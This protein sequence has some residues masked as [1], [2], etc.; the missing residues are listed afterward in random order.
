MN[1]KNLASKH[2]VLVDESLKKAKI[3]DLITISDERISTNLDKINNYKEM[4]NNPLMSEAYIAARRY[5]LN[6]DVAVKAIE[7]LGHDKFQEFTDFYFKII[8][9]DPKDYI[10]AVAYAAKNGFCFTPKEVSMLEQEV[11]NFQNKFNLDLTQTYHRDVPGSSSHYHEHN[12]TRA[13][14]QSSG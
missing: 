9:G 13:L 5:E 8:K 11:M 6:I 7:L 10:E 12:A 1:N 3:K 14:D 2:H 4:Q